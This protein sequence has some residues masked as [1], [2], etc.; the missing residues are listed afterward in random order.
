[1]R[2]KFEKG[3]T[4][5][6]MAAAFV[7]FIYSNGIVIGAVNLYVQTY[8][9]DM[10]PEKFGGGAYYLCKATEENKAEYDQYAARMRRSKFKQVANK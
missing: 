7:D 6:K 9:D 4:P 2:I 1:M 8:D 5:E 3:I 10:K